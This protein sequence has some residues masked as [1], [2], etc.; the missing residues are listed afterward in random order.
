MPFPPPKKK[1]SRL[2]RM[3]QRHGIGGAKPLQ[4]YRGQGS[5]PISL[6][7]GWKGKKTLD[8]LSSLPLFSVLKLQG[9]GLRAN[10]FATW[11]DCCVRRQIM[12]VFWHRLMINE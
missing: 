1:G 11:A 6:L 4:Q 7:A 2:G 3:H 12:K 8:G 9:P 5:I 10:A